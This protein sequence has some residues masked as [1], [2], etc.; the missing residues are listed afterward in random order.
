MAKINLNHNS[1]GFSLME[2]M[3][4][5]TI[6]SFFITA[7]MVGHGGNISD[8]T[9]MEEELTLRHLCD[10]KIQSIIINPPEFKESLT[11]APESGSFEE[12]EYKNYEFSVEYQ[13]LEIPN[14]TSETP[15]SL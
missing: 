2:V 10:K 9:F 5:L 14:L 12:D 3:I 1:R 11:L 13:R 4:A 7:F 8:S 15:V 6:F